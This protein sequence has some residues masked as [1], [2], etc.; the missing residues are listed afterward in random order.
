[1]RLFYYFL[2]NLG[3]SILG[4]KVIIKIPTETIIQ[5]YN[6]HCFCGQSP[7][8]VDNKI[9]FLTLQATKNAPRKTLNILTIK[10]GKTK[11]SNDNPPMYAK[12]L[13]G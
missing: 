10:T 13:P 2:D 12:S 3:I 1:M 7:K 6:D 5:A 9:K 4:R 8:H 11:K